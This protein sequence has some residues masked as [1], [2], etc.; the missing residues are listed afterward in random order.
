MPKLTALIRTRNDAARIGRVLESLRPCDEFLI[1]DD[2]S[3]D[4]TIRVAREYGA[5][6]GLAGAEDRNH[7]ELAQNDWILCVSPAEALTEALEAA[8]F[9]W[10][11]IEHGAARSFRVGIREETRKGWNS[12]PP[13]TRL[14]N[15]RRVGIG[16]GMPAEDPSG[17]LLDG[18]LLRFCL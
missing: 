11:Q 17:H 6:V 1:I 9:E 10:K 8:L 16:D 2:D 14:V 12:L 13:V 5:R 18:D 15:R 7:A 4:D 3:S